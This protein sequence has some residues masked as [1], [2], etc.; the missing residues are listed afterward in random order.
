MKI[1][2]GA[3]IADSTIIIIGQPFF[4]WTNILK[5]NKKR[6]LP[7]VLPETCW[8]S[9]FTNT[10]STWSVIAN[11]C[12]NFCNPP[13]LNS[14]TNIR[15]GGVYILWDEPEGA[16][17]NCVSSY[18]VN[19]VSVPYDGGINRVLISQL[20]PISDCSALTIT[21]TCTPVVNSIGHVTSSSLSAT[22]DLAVLLISKYC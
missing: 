14:V 2:K 4:H 19:G 18:S 5:V 20:R 16:P 22:V 17:N 12:V 15:R 21:V 1:K 8:P 7:G 9:S 6:K 11:M 3:C 13:V 10:I